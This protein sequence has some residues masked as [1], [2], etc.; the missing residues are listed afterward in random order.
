MDLGLDLKRWRSRCRV[1]CLQLVR[2]MGGHEPW[3]ALK[4]QANRWGR[5][6]ASMAEVRQSRHNLS[7]LVKRTS[8]R[9][10]MLGLCTEPWIPPSE[11]VLPVAIEYPGANL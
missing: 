10:H 5:N 4:R 6:V 8:S 1:K 11:G 9:K 3:L 7:D 2:G